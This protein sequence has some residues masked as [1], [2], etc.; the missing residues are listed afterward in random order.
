MTLLY[1]RIFRGNHFRSICFIVL[2]ANLIFMAAT[3]LTDCLIC[4]PVAYRWN[5][6]GS[7]HCGT[8]KSLDLFIGIV[9][10]VLDFTTVILPMPGVWR[11][12]MPTNRKVV[13][14]SV[15][16]LGV[17]YLLLHPLFN[18]AFDANCKSLEFA[19]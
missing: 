12:Q 8:Q 15:F 11:L 5:R 6:S 1:L 19:S 10:L 9:N 13:L 14:S 16:A 18:G 2:G 4:Q 17:G 7:G 3:I